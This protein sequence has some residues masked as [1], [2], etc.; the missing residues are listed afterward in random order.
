[1]KR[2]ESSSL[3][4]LGLPLML[5]CACTEEPTPIPDPSPTMTP[6][7]TPSPTPFDEIGEITPTPTPTPVPNPLSRVEI[8]PADFQL[9]TTSSLA[10]HLKAFREQGQEVTPTAIQWVST[11]PGVATIDATGHATAVAPGSTDITAIADGVESNAAVLEVLATGVMYVK[12]IDADLKTP[13]ANASV[14]LGQDAAQVFTTD[15]DGN[16]TVTGDFSGP[17]T[18][19]GTQADFHNATLLSVLD[20][21]VTIP[22]RSKASTTEG[23]YSGSVDFSGMG[24]LPDNR[25]I[26][27]GLITRSFYGNPLSL[28]TNTIIGSY[29]KVNVCGADTYIPSNIVGQVPST[30][31][32]D[33]NLSLY[34]VPGPSGTY[35][36]YM[37]AGDLVANDVLSW[38][39]DTT[40]FSNLGKLLI[41]I[42][43]MYEFSYN[44]EQDISI[45]APNDTTGVLLAP[46]GTTDSVLTVKVPKLPSGIDPS[47]L[48]VAFAIADTG[49]RGFLP[50][51]IAGARESSTVAVY[52]AHEFDNIPTYG[53]VMAAESG[54]GAAGAYVATM[55]QPTP[56]TTVVTPPDFLQLL[57]PD[58]LQTDPTTRNFVWYPVAD[59]NVYRSV[60]TWTHKVNKK[61]TEHLVW[62]VYA[63][64]E[65]T[66]FTLPEIPGSLPFVGYD[67]LD[68]NDGYIN[69]ELWAYDNQGQDF[70]DFTSNPALS[71]YDSSVDLYRMSRNFIL[72]L[73][74]TQ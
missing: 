60:F 15:A 47:Y 74:E 43:N 59:S 16:A 44:F 65:V 8:G 42:E 20:R 23:K 7:V 53:L 49:E 2:L 69:W 18:L 11:N 34:S 48:P 24:N 25:H 39:T 46:A 1:M 56:G 21:S 63:P 64:I 51:G 37:L 58:K 57:Q 66:S 3:L 52:H 70:N 55:A 32:Q 54:V 4:P 33:P 30:C 9:D 6:V 22:L 14:Y 29:R 72:D 36:S 26:R 40:I 45:T 10:Y 17:Q 68:G 71:I 5:L 41:T 13:V 31:T 12:V 61:W 27:V 50:I 73:L 19:T 35:D 38:L 62:D 67:G 28:D